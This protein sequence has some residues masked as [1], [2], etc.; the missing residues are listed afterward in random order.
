MGFDLHWLQPT[1]KC[2]CGVVT[3][4]SCTA[5]TP[6]A[7]MP[8]HAACVRTGELGRVSQPTSTAKEPKAVSRAGLAGDARLDSLWSRLIIKRA[9]SSSLLQPASSVARGSQ[10]CKR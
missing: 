8:S 9:T 7:W 5:R 1:W 6:I 10:A 4:P 3:C 2:S